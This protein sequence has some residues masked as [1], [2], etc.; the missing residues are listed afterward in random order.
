MKNCTFPWT[1]LV[2]NP[3]GYFTTCCVMSNTSKFTNTHISEVDNISEYFYGKYDD[4]KKEFKDKGWRNIPDCQTCVDRFDAGVPHTQYQYS[5]EFNPSLNKLQYLE[6]TTSN[7]CNQM[8]VTCDSGFS[9]QWTREM[10]LQF[11]RD[12]HYQKHI[13]TN[14]DI[15]TICTGLSDLTALNIKG[16]E[17]FA[18][19]RNHKILKRLFEVNDECIV[20]IVTNGSIIPEVYMDLI[21]RNPKRFTIAVSVDAIGKRYEWI[22]ST[23]WEKTDNMLKELYYQTGVRVEINSVLSIFNAAHL[24]DIGDWI[25]ES[26]YITPGEIG[27]RPNQSFCRNKVDWPEW[28]NVE[29]VF[30]QDQI[31]SIPDLSFDLTS[32]FDPLHYGNSVRYTKVMNKIRGFDMDLWGNMG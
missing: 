2:I 10:E 30:T 5:Q 29:T 17:P 19:I 1:G 27:N 14:K 26:E 22:R 8:C 4:T 6:F 13:L 3:Q 7:V 12:N 25:W 18:D 21:F 11:G 28:S 15:D 24:S 9:N 31:D 23:P 20:T 16:G 32:R